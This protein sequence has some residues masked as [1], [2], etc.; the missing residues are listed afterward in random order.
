MIIS[1]FV[2]KYPLKNNYMAY[3]HSLRMKPVFLSSLESSE[4]DNA[5]LNGTI[6]NL[7]DETIDSLRKY[8]IIVE[9][10]DDDNDILEYVRKN[11]PSPYISL[12]YFVLTEQCNLA[13]KYCFLGNSDIHSHKITT[14]SMSHETADKALRF[15]ARQT[16]QDDKQFAD[17]KEIIFYGGEPLINFDTIK[18][19]INRCKYYQKK[20]LISPKINYSMVTNGLLLDEEKAVFL[21]DHNVSV[22]ISIDGS[23]GQCNKERVDRSGNPIFEKVLSKIDLMRKLKVR[24]GLSVTLTDWTILNV[25]SFIEFI[26]KYGIKSLCFNILMKSKN[27]EKDEAYYKKATD[28]II[29]FFN[30]TKDM[31]IY[32]DRMQRKL[33]AFIDSE[34]YFSDC[35][36]T[37][38]SQIVI[39]PDGGVGLCHGCMENRKY[40][41][42]NIDDIDLNVADNKT[43]RD[44]IKFSPVFKEHCLSCEALGI[45]G[46]GCPKNASEL[47]ISQINKIDYSFCLH[48]KKILKFFIEELFNIICS[49]KK[50]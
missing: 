21:R 47:N 48:S 2:K 36:A 31:H 23:N 33:Q 49:N 45:C 30:K 8:M 29:E 26:K 40:F 42:G 28:F 12:A 43:V 4:L 10:K 14:Y 7:P 44:W 9:S 11:V 50:L 37:S 19:I 13:C 38:G 46:G 15:F 6:P 20:G 5:I 24:F 3:Y 39:T 17:E 35:A 25:D 32:E 18:Y 16:R 41:I 34:L 22:S 27:I 1:R